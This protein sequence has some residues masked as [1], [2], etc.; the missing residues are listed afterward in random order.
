M[1]MTRDE[2]NAY[3]K[4]LAEDDQEA[5]RLILPGT[6]AEFDQCEEIVRCRDCKH[7]DGYYH[8]DRVTHWNTGDDY[9]SRGEKRR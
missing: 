5:V 8:C 4:A 2:Y 3:N 6:I 9:C 1:N 7:A